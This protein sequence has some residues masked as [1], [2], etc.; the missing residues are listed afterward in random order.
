M[1]KNRIVTTLVGLPVLIIAVWFDRPIHWF[2]LFI[3]LCGIIAAGEFYRMVARARV[4]P[5]TYFGILWSLLFIISADNTISGIISPYLDPVKA[6]LFLLVLA[7]IIQLIWG[8]RRG[9]KKDS[10]DRW[11]WT[12]AGVLYVGVLLSLLV[13]LRGMDNGR[14]W[15]LFTLLASFASDTT[16]FFIGRKWGRHKLAPAISPG[17]TR[18]GAIAGILGA[19]IISLLFVPEQFGSLANPLYLSPLKYYSAVLLGLAVS[20]FGQVGDLVESMIKRNMNAKDSGWLLPGHGGILD[21]MDSVAFAGIVVYYF[22][23]WVIQ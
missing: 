10:T 12:M 14:N 8:L 15:V 13:S 11:A 2:T 1:L 5:Y 18:E 9:D 7:I 20:V 23:L 4:S 3:S 19:V 22:V 6:P 21:R 16:A 17:K